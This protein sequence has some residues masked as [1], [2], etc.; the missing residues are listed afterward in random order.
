MILERQ[1]AEGWGAKVIDR[2]AKDLKKE[3]PD[4]GWSRRT[5]HY[6]QRLA[7]LFPTDDLFVQ[8][9]AAQIPW[10]STMMLLDK[11]GGDREAFSW[12]A[13]ET[14][15]NRLSRK[16]LEELVATS[17]HLRRG[18]VISNYDKALAADQSSL[19]QESLNDPVTLNYLGLAETIRERALEDQLVLDVQRFMSELG[20]GLAFVA[21]Q[22]HL[23]VGGDDFYVDLLFFN[24]V[25]M[26]FMVVELKTEN[27]QP[28]HA[29]QTNFYVNAVERQLRDP[30]KHQPTVGLILVPGKNNEVVEHSLP[31]L[32]PIAVATYTLDAIPSL[33]RNRSPAPQ[34]PQSDED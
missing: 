2:L 14:A 7:A 20:Y 3:F 28:A 16:R 33:R 8:Q 18:Q 30:A 23:I 11:H 31:T 19:A 4:M 24:Y 10:G 13:E 21:R 29:G 6:A 27:Y 34:L 26:C 17:A 25:A 1:A 9:P 5:L 32:A 12:Y 22:K 15:K